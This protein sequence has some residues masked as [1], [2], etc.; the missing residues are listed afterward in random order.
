MRDILPKFDP[1]S[2]GVAPPK[3][4]SFVMETVGFG[5]HLAED[6]TDADSPSTFLATA[7]PETECVIPQKWRH[8]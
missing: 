2:G 5:V 1:P 3:V 4:L 8:S 7:K 6:P